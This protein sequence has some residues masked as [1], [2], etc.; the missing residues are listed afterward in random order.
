METRR[1]FIATIPAA[2][3]AANL[4]AQ[5]AANTDLVLWYKQP[6]EIWTEALPVG[7]GRSGAMVLGGIETERLQINEDTL[8]SGSPRDWN[9]PQAKSN[10]PEIRRLVLQ[11]EAYNEADALCKKMQG[12]FNE[13]YQPLGNL[14]LKMAHSA[15]TN[16]TRELDLDRAVARVSYQANRVTYSREVFSSAVDQVIVIRL[17]CDQ[18]GKLDFGATMD[19]LLHYQCTAA[20][21]DTLRLSG[22]AP[23]HVDPNYVGSPNP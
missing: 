16:Y 22:K 18:P 10:L 2:I 5:P 12:P 4:I 11:Q 19:S 1:E 9:N 17:S 3:G 7:N 8:W 23:A 6:A 15:G 14:Y 13:S 20:G 21:P